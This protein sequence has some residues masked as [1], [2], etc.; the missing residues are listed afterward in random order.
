MTRA[1]SAQP[2]VVENAANC[3]NP[4][5]NPH[6]ARGK[7]C[8]TSGLCHP[9]PQ[10]A[11]AMPH[12]HAHHIQ[13]IMCYKV[14][15]VTKPANYRTVFALLAQASQATREAPS[16]SVAVSGL[17]CPIIARKPKEGPHRRRCSAN[18]CIRSGQEA[19]ALDDNASIQINFEEVQTGLGCQKTYWR[20]Q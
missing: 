19:P 7:S 17:R 15:S 18:A 20:S 13:E 3:S 14:Q 12:M 16:D 4:A 1:I 6:A 10:C 8:L 9:L 2:A 11:L 5:P